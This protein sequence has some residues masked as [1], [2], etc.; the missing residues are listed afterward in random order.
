DAAG[1]VTITGRTKDIINRG[2]EK[3]SAQEI[4]GL[5][6]RYPTVSDAAVGAA[7]HARL[8][9]EPA[10]FIIVRAGDDVPDGELQA[11][12]RAEGVAPQKIPRIWVPVDEFPRTPSGK[13][14]K[15]DL[16]ERLPP[17]PVR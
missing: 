11:F 3:L 9:E 10:A 13:V 1:C 4:E 14:K 16:V 15:Y 6:R 17:P 12:L 7:P 5:I 8:G 2:G